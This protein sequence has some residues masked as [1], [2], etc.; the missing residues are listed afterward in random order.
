MTNLELFPRGKGAAGAA[1]GTP[2]ASSG[3]SNSNTKQDGKKRK[4]PS[5]SP[6]G[7]G[8]GG[9][10]EKEWLFGAGG[11]DK[12]KDSRAKQSAA[13]KRPRGESGAA[14]AATGI[15]AKGKVRYPTAVNSYLHSYIFRA[16]RI[17]ALLELLESYVMVLMYLLQQNASGRIWRKYFSAG[18]RAVHLLRRRAL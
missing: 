1:P 17:V 12:E 6:G 2:K 10:K 8:G 15:G 7:G 18:V 9:G 4:A 16:S 13:G 14:A 5:A 11:G 3:G